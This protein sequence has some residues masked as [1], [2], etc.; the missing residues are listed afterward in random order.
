[1]AKVILCFN[2]FCKFESFTPTLTLSF[3]Q[4][5]HGYLL[6]VISHPPF[7]KFLKSVVFTTASVVSF[8]MSPEISCSLTSPPIVIVTLSRSVVRLLKIADRKDTTH[9]LHFD[10][11]NFRHSSYYLPSTYIGLDCSPLTRGSHRL[12]SSTGNK[13]MTRFHESVLHA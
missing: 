8:V 1:M 11:V 9:V 12:Y 5:E 6:T 7:L 10:F 4:L 13:N 3:N 2:S